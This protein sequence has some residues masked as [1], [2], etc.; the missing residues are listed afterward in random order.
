MVCTDSCHGRENDIHLAEG[1]TKVLSR[2]F[3]ISIDAVFAA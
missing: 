2:F 3:T 1:A